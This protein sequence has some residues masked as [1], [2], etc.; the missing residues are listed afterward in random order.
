MKYMGIWKG[1]VNEV[2]RPHVAYDNQVTYINSES[3]GL[4]IP[5]VDVHD[6]VEAG[7]LL[8]TVVN[9]LTGTVEQKVIAPSSGTITAIRE[10]PAI[11]MGS[12]LARIV[13]M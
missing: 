3:G 5:N 13:E 4:F 2:E 8:G 11:E 1:E 7:M 9:V 12:L 6:R 10:Y